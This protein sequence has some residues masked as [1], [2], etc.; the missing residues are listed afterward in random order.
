MLHKT[1]ADKR[2]SSIEPGSGPVL[3]QIREQL[4]L[5]QQK[6]AEMAGYQDKIRISH[7][8]RNGIGPTIFHQ[9][10]DSLPLSPQDQSL[11]NLSAGYGNIQDARTVAHLFQGTFEDNRGQLGFRDLSGISASP[12]TLNGKLKELLSQRNMTLS[13]L[14]RRANVDPSTF[15]RWKNNDRNPNPRTL[16][17]IAEVLKLTPQ[18]DL[19]LRILANP[20]RS[21]LLQLVHQVPPLTLTK[22]DSVQIPPPI[23]VKSSID[24]HLDTIRGNIARIPADK[25][26]KAAQALAQ[27]SGTLASLL[28]K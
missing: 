19:E 5:T 2:R 18:E 20:T 23:E 15:T 1:D 6:V 26:E 13:E 8:E 21:E 17:R 22:P 3:R 11:A 14:S 24:T 7:A 28:S 25:Q 16:L 12:Q 9:I 10:V 4:G 27:F